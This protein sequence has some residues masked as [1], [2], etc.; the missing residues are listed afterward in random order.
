MT[1]AAIR[2]PAINAALGTPASSPAGTFDRLEAF[3]T[4]FIGL[5]TVVGGIWFIFQ[6]ITG[7]VAWVSAG[8]DKDGVQR[9]QKK[10]TNAVIGL[11]VLIFAYTLIALIGY[12]LGYNVFAISSALSRVIQ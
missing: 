3:V 5:A 1:L 8:S 7:A 4:L 6:I 9:A 10:F 11:I 12:L 2:N